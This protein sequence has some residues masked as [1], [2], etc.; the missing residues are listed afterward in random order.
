MKETHYNDERYSQE[1]PKTVTPNRRKPKE[2]Q[3]H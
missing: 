3:K 1:T 2:L